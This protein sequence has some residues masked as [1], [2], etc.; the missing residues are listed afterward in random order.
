MQLNQASPKKSLDLPAVEQG[1]CSIYFGDPG[2]IQSIALL[3]F[4]SHPLPPTQDSFLY[5]NKGMKFPAHSKNI[6]IP[7]VT[8]VR[9]LS[10]TSQASFA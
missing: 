2:W 3:V 8:A 7:P 6:Q 9:N 10:G 4:T 5:Q 1:A